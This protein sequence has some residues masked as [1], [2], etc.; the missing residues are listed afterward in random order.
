[1]N[2]QAT[3]INRSTGPSRGHTMKENQRNNSFDSVVEPT[4]W[5][6][7]AG[8]LKANVVNL[9]CNVKL[10]N[11]KSW[12]APGRGQRSDHTVNGLDAEAA[13]A[14]AEAAADAEALGRIHTIGSGPPDPRTCSVTVT[15]RIRRWVHTTGVW[16]TDPKV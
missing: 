1:M 11:R 3:N 5:H 2:T 6:Y 9:T 8:I 15:L 13:A 12:L 16:G 14:E 10:A 4:E 7:N